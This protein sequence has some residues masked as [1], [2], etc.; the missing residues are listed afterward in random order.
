M[1]SDRADVKSR[2]VA[3]AAEIVG[4]QIGVNLTIRELAKKAN[5][6]IAAVNYY[7]NSKDNLM[8][9]VEQTFADKFK[10]INMFLSQKEDLPPQDRLFQW[11][12]MLMT[13]LMENPGTIS[14]FV[15][16]V[17]SGWNS[18]LIPELIHG[19]GNCL[20]PVVKKLLKCDDFNAAYT[21]SLHIMSCIITPILIYHA[22]SSGL[23]IDISNQDYRKEYIRSFLDYFN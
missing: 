4:S 8:Q 11:A 20:L 14:M 22:S 12:D 21:A 17:V 15:V 16:N 7:F 2:I 6:N 10:K 18:T 3:A 9:E 1:D 5:V 23:D 13:Y 19:L